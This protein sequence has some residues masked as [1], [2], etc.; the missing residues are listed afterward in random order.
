MNG[1]KYLRPFRCHSGE[2]STGSGLFWA[3]SEGV[4]ME[5][6]SPSVAAA[7][8]SGCAQLTAG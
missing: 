8:L 2:D 3:I 1:K 6:G 5:A 7:Q 4:E